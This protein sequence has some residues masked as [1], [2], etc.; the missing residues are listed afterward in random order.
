LPDS[1]SM[2]NSLE[3]R[4]LGWRQFAAPTQRLISSA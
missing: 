2:G 3:Q 4:R 1:L